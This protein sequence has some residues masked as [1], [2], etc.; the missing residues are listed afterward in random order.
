M[1]KIL[2]IVILCGGTS[3]YAQTGKQLVV[4]KV[5]P[6]A[7]VKAAPKASVKTSQKAMAKAELQ[8]AN[9][10]SF[11]AGLELRTQSKIKSSLTDK[12][13]EQ[14]ATAQNIGSSVSV[15]EVP[16]AVASSFS[17]IKDATNTA[18]STENGNW[19]AYYDM[20][21][22]KM[23]SAF[24]ATGESLYT[25]TKLPRTNLPKP[26]ITYTAN[27]ITTLSNQDIILIE[28]P[29]QSPIYQLTLMNGNVVYVDHTGSTASNFN[30]NALVIR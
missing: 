23:V 16:D 12:K 7:S 14:E 11:K 10:A 22:Y 13:S 3:L 2:G 21:G 17:E 9:R 8:A 29:G 15:K 27:T 26:V 6:T 24:T 4:T 30:S 25:A 28:A 1:K 18:W 19:Y 20:K 5:T